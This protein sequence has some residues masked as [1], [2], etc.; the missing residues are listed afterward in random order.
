MVDPH[1]V[2]IDNGNNSTKI[3]SETQNL[4][5]NLIPMNDSDKSKQNQNQQNLEVNCSSVVVNDP[6]T[7][8]TTTTTTITKILADVNEIYEHRQNVYDKVDD[9]A[10]IM[11]GPLSR[12]SIDSTINENNSVSVTTTTT[13]TTTTTAFLAA[14]NGTTTNTLT[15]N[16]FTR[17]I[18][19]INAVNNPQKVCIIVK[20]KQEISESDDSYSEQTLPTTSSINN[21]SADNDD[22]NGN[23]DDD[24]NGNN[25]TKIE[26]NSAEFQLQNTISNTTIATVFN[27][28]DATPLSVPLTSTSKMDSRKVEPLRININRD[29]IKTKIKLGTSS[30]NASLDECDDIGEMPHEN[31]QSYPK[32]IIK[33]IV[34]PTIDTE[35][36]HHNHNHSTSSHAPSSSS[37]SSQEAIPKLK[38]KKVDTNNSNSILTPLPTHSATLNSDDIQGNYQTHLLSESSSS[39]PK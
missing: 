8:T 27:Q 34:K 31:Q 6:A 7:T 9:S 17:D 26:H 32:I 38:I 3:I 36:H 14:Q 1:Q 2:L 11:C 5:A 12:N 22:S 25:C 30:N 21:N 35:H 16:N 33:P 4:P 24:D 10:E 20:N 19:Q 39:V 15:P 29:P 18:E 37:T 13:T 28:I 23:D